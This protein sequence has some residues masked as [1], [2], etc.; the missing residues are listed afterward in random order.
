MTSFYV[1]LLAGCLL[2][3][4]SLS[5]LQADEKLL[6]SSIEDSLNTRIS[7]AVMQEAYRRLGKDIEII[8]SSGRRAL[9][10][11][12]FGMVDGELFRIDVVEN[13]YEN[14]IKVPVPINRLDAIVITRSTDVRIEN[15]SDLASYRIG[16][17]RGILF[18]ELATR[19]QN[20][21]ILVDSNAQLLR[22]LEA[23]RV[24]A[25]IIARI[26]GLNALQ[27][28]DN[29]GY[30]LVSPVIA[31]YPLFHHIH[32]DNLHLLPAITQ[33]LQELQA[34]SFIE[35]TRNKLVAELLKL[36]GHESIQ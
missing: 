16:I 20:K 28:Y 8:P 13:H 2:N 27:Q 19:A 7:F 12:N 23:D 21:V 15:W 18:S 34:S 9:E 32:K 33:V 10:M 30:L 6:F 1:P 22:I 17:R 25:I 35:N 36:D 5:S 4:L 29:N 26:N 3:L 24:D 31:S 11:A 14:L